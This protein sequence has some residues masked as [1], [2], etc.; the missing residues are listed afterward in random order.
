MDVSGGLFDRKP[1]GDLS[2]PLLRSDMQHAPRSW[3]D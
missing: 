1:S 3:R 2:G